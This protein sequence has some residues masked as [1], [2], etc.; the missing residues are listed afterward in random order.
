MARQ[1]G[2]LGS[3]QR[4]QE[5][6]A[7]NRGNSRLEDELAGMM[8]GRNKTDPAGIMRDQYE[9]YQD[10]FVPVE[11]Q[12]AGQ[13]ADKGEIET[14]SRGAGAEAGRDVERQKAQYERSLGLSGIKL[15]TKQREESAKLFEQG[16]RGA[17]AG[18]TTRMRSGLYDQN[19]RTA[20]EYTSLGR[21]LATGA[22]SSLMQA[23]G[24]ATQRETANDQIDAQDKQAKTAA[25]VMIIAAIF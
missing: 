4:A 11:R 7:R 3:R 20:G 14:R 19:L 12:L 1:T 25:A 6:Q 2:I 9:Y 22:K 15:D 17:Q 10:V 13:I 5:Q 24:L 21:G 16:A 18:A 23:S 8:A